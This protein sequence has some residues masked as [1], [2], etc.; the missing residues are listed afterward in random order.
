MSL[1]FV[2]CQRLDSIIPL[3]QV[4]LAFV[5]FFAVVVIYRTLLS[6]LAAIPGPWQ[7]KISGLYVV[8]ETVRLRK[9]RSIHALFSKYGPLVRI[10]PNQVAIRD[11]TAARL[12][13]DFPKGN[14]Y[15]DFYVLGRPT[16][17]A[18]L[19]DVCGAFREAPRGP[20]T[21]HAHEH[22]HIDI[23]FAFVVGV[24]AQAVDGL[25]DQQAH[26]LSDAISDCP[27]EMT[28]FIGQR[29]AMPRLLWAVV[30]RWPNER[31][32]RFCD[33]EKILYGFA[34][35]RYEEFVSSSIVD[36][37]DQPARD[38]STLLA[39]L[40]DHVAHNKSATLTK[41]DILVECAG[42]FVA[43]VE[44]SSTTLSFAFWELSRR[45]DVVRRIRDE[46]A[47][48]NINKETLEV[49]SLPYLTAFTK[50]VLRNYPFAMRAL[51]CCC[52]AP[53]AVS[54]L[55]A[56]AS[57]TSNP[58]C[59]DFFAPISA[60]AQNL[61]DIPDPTKGLVP[62]SNATTLVAGTF[63]ISFRFCGPTVDNAAAAEVLQILVHGAWYR[64][65]YWLWPQ[66]PEKYNYGLLANARGYPVLAYD[67]LG[68]GLSERPDGRTV[69]QTALEIAIGVQIVQRA[70]AGTLHK[71]LQGFRKVVQVGHS[72]GSVVTNGVIAK[73]PGALDGIVLTS[74]THT[75]SRTFDLVN[76]LGLEAA[77][78]AVP[79]RFGLLPESYM[80]NKNA[81][82]KA[83]A[84][85]GPA[86][87]FDR[88]VL[89]FD[90]ATRDTL[91]WGE[92]QTLV[93]EIAG[94]VVGF[95]GHVLTV[96]GANDNNFCTT[97]PGCDNLQAEAGKT[98][99]PNAAR[100]EIHLVPYA[101]HNLNL[102][103]S[104]PDTYR[105]ILDWISGLAL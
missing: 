18:A 96:T 43:G 90:E 6:P 41:E 97:V 78:K 58:H 101:G 93:S 33:S 9:S 92:L 14:M 27:K 98:Y 32:R 17:F 56:A 59:T 64:K 26:V 60:S 85:Y 65:N 76:V 84:E 80:T 86:G 3:T 7:A 71:S 30:R 77:R 89:L 15:A 46:L 95:T 4:F 1:P 105:T 53:L 88:N 82:G 2:L 61:V 28:L 62:R 72:L 55:L 68:D 102:L 40:M 70:R 38:T 50:E 73:D 37:E 8:Y 87:S 20:A 69:V 104:A 47:D 91:T 74:Y 24:R 35:Q 29:A 81:T 25:R 31:W 100:A 48:R 44:T 94:P 54:A 66:Q 99:Y 42:H 75:P 22:R 63:D 103:F 83:E 79:L 11:G 36:T 49:H 51:S 34:A 5:S 39:R 45:P 12:I 23:I 67:R 16:T 10:G 19:Q 52:V 13:G 57:P 21:L